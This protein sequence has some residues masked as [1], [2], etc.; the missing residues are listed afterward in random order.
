MGG[1]EPRGEKEGVAVEGM[2]AYLEEDFPFVGTH[3]KISYKINNRTNQQAN[4]ARCSYFFN[5]T[6]INKYH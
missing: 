2:R 5:V 4:K 1:R 3:R 6:V